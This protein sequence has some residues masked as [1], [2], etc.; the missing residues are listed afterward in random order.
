MS[1]TGLGGGSQRHW[2]LYREDVMGDATDN[3]A[4]WADRL[5]NRHS[6][7]WTG[8]IEEAEREG[9]R[10]SSGSVEAVFWS[11]VCGVIRQVR[12][13]RLSNPNRK[14]DAQPSLRAS[15]APVGAEC[16][17]GGRNKNCFKCDGTGIVRATSRDPS[18]GKMRHKRESCPICGKRLGVGGV[19]PHIRAKHP[20]A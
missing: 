18:S 6:G 4:T 8:A 20:N 13:A 11:G 14:R 10:Y 17:C 16:S 7:N 3:E 9:R 1:G 2:Q 19:T 12:A 15:G 5:V